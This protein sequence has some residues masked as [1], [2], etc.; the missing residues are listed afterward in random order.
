MFGCTVWDR[1]ASSC[2]KP[3]LRPKY[4]SELCV[5]RNRLSSCRSTSPAIDFPR[6]ATNLERRLNYKLLSLPRTNTTFSNVLS[7]ERLLD[8]R[9][10]RI[11]KS[12]SSCLYGRSPARA[13]F[14]FSVFTG[15]LHRDPP[16]SN[17][18]CSLHGTCVRIPWQGRMDWHDSI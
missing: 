18:S 11:D 3:W 6:I 13:R 5:T 17:T 10:R 1:A 8:F 16:R 12:N 15:S 4:L 2:N 14:P 7:R 9:T